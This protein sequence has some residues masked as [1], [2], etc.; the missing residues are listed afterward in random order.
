MPGKRKTTLKDLAEYAHLSVSTVSGVVN[1][2]EGFSEETRKKVWDA[3]HALDYVPNA[4]A[5]KLRSGRDAGSRLRSGL[6]MRIKY[7][8]IPGKNDLTRISPRN[9][10]RPPHAAAIS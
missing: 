10:R 7:Y 8:G 4:Q 6:L 3:V 5:K 9:S 2:L 1:N